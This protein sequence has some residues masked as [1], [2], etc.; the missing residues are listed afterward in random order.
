[1]PRAEV[2]TM[3]VLVYLHLLPYDKENLLSLWIYQKGLGGVILGS[4]CVPG[5]RR[6]RK[7]LD[8]IG[9]TKIDWFLVGLHLKSGRTQ[10]HCAVSGWQGS[11]PILVWQ[12]NTEYLT[13]CHTVGL[14]CKQQSSRSIA[15]EVCVMLGLGCEAHLKTTHKQKAHFEVLILEKGRWHGLV[16]SHCKKTPPGSPDESSSCLLWTASLSWLVSAVWLRVKL[17]YATPGICAF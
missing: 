1:M 7:V 16:V 3:R 9:W 2:H 8:W 15:A 6:S 4:G 14:G 17:W 11:Q 10:L 13:L 5:D 12:S